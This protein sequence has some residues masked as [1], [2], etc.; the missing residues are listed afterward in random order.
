MKPLAPVTMARRGVSRMTDRHADTEAQLGE[1]K[2]RIRG[3]E[4]DHFANEVDE[5]YA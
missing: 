4:L 5:L 2:R 1:C 3:P